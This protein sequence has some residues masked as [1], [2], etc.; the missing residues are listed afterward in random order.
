M[1]VNVTQTC[2]RTFAYSF[3]RTLFYCLLWYN[4]TSRWLRG[5][6]ESCDD[7]DDIGRRNHNPWQI[8][9]MICGD[10]W[11]NCTNPHSWR[12]SSKNSL[13]QTNAAVLSVWI[14][15]H[16]NKSGQ[17]RTSHDLGRSRDLINLSRSRSDKKIHLLGLKMPWRADQP[18]DN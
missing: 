10:I 3:F 8:S 14:Y 2:V 12:S 9:N 6:V 17:S 7:G 18:T 15:L 5:V 4:Q 11:E 13:Q 1:C 16:G